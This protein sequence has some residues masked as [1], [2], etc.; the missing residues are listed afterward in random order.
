VNVASVP[1]PLPVLE[2][3]LTAVRR[4][5]RGNIFTSFLLPVLFLWGMGISVGGYVD[6]A[7]GLDVPYLDYIAPGVL[8]S[9]VVQIAVGE[10]MWPVLGAFEWNRL[11]HAMRATPL[12]ASDIVG[13]EFSFLMLR[14]G[15]PAAA[16]VLVMLAFGAVGS[17]WAPAAI[18]AAMLTG[19]SVTGATM[20][21]SASIKSDNMFAL[22][23]RFV[24]IPMT[25]FAGVFF[26]VETMPLV[27]RWIA[28][29]S[30]LWHGV[31]LCRYAT[32]GLPSALPV[33]AHVAYLA[34]WT[35]LGYAL[36][37]TRFAKRLA[38]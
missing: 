18:V 23:Y 7:G 31:E 19:A 28:Y 1:S 4:T 11:Y 26:P 10:A 30:P 8:A 17:W 20:A 9:T 34:L 21:Y 13:G 27:A 22:L 32:M 37:R 12:R 2:H 3:R 24:V 6:R 35:V 25:L 29:L 38:D 5:W 16:F 15:V 14:V 36:A 33:S